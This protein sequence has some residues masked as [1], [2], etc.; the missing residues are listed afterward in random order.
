MYLGLLQE[1]LSQNSN[2]SIPSA[3]PVPAPEPVIV[4]KKI[5]IRKSINNGTD[6]KDTTTK[7]RR[8]M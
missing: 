4:K 7:K 2:A 8:I 3:A 6:N 5:L 1:T